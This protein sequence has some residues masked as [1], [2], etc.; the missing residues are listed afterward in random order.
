ME[1]EKRLPRLRNDY[2]PSI[3]NCMIDPAASRKPQVRVVWK[4]RRGG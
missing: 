1:T 4:E 2:H 3:I